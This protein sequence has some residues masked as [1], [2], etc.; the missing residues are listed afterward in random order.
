[1]GIKTHH[2]KVDGLFSVNQIM[3][4]ACKVCGPE[5]AAF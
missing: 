4:V 1:M 3:F 5:S 2:S